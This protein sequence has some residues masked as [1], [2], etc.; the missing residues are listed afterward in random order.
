MK[1]R[2]ALPLFLQINKAI[3]YIL[4]ILNMECFGYI[5]GSRLKI[6]QKIII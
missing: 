4:N 3:H 5:I 1:D 2:I 6:M